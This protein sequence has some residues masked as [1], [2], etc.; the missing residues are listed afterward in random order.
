MRN[1]QLKKVSAGLAVAGAVGIAAYVLGI[2]PWHLRWGA[3]DEELNEPLI[4]DEL[5]PNPKLRATHA[6]TINAPARDVWPWLVQMGQTRGGSRWT[7]A[8][9]CS[10]LHGGLHFNPPSNT[11]ALP[12]GETLKCLERQMPARAWKSLVSR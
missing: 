8:P 6:I 1:H 9:L 7:S 10:S 4:G 3:T 12:S 11:E 2:R 5:A